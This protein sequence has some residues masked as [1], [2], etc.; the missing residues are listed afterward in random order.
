MAP[1]RSITP[2]NVHQVPPAAWQAPPRVGA[3]PGDAVHWLLPVGRTWQSIVAGYVALLAIFLWILGP[4]A[5]GFGIAALWAS[6]AGHGHG[7]GRAWFA[8]VVGAL[9]TFVLMLLVVAEL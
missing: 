8:V 5:L 6:A 7:R 4:V 2:L 1:G 3:S 9:V